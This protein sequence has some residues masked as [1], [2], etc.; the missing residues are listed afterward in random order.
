MKILLVEECPDQ[1]MI[2]SFGIRTAGHEVSFC[3]PRDY[4][5]D[6]DNSRS[7]TTF[8]GPEELT[9]LVIENGYEGVIL[10]RE[11][12]NHTHLEPSI[13]FSYVRKLLNSDYQ[14]RVVVT[15]SSMMS[16][17]L[18]QEAA[19]QD[20]DKLDLVGKPYDYLDLIE[21]LKP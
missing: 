18:E 14:G 21:K 20:L 10:N 15:T 1:R 5:P 19:E 6:D 13:V 7:L 2:L 11:A 9:R 16:D 12:F 4:V 3:L 17:A 8:E